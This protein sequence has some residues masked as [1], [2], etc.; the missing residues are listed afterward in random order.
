MNTSFFLQAEGH[1][2][3][4]TGDQSPI[5]KYASSDGKS[6]STSDNDSSRSFREDDSQSDRESE[7]ARS[8]NSD[9]DH[10]SQNDFD[11]SLFSED[12]SNE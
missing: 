6:D 9:E 11:T 10:S 7:D 5:H 8:S 12:S 2:A 3:G 1:S 4:N